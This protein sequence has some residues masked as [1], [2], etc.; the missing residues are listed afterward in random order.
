[1][2]GAQKLRSEAHLQVRRNDEVEAQRRRWTFYETI[3]FRLFYWAG[4]DGEILFQDREGVFRS[5][6]RSPEYSIPPPSA[7]PAVDRRGEPKR[8][9]S[10]PGEEGKKPLPALRR[11]RFF[12]GPE[13]SG[14]RSGRG[15]S[16]TWCETTIRVFPRALSS[17]I[18]RRISFFPSQSS[19]TVGSSRIR[20]FGSWT[21][22]PANATRRISPLL[23]SKGERRRNF[24]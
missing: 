18:S 7:R 19:P 22:T 11:R 13:R 14:G 17:R 24:S 10:L 6:R 2:Q 15:R 20:I 4:G 23:N 9:I 1:M 16:S 8:E 12:P 5:E 3:K 21:K